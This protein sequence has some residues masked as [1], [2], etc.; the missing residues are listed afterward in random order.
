[1]RCFENGV[2]ARTTYSWDPDV[3]RDTLYL[4]YVYIK[5]TLL[6]IYYPLKYYL[7]ILY[8][9]GYTIVYTQHILTV[10]CYVTMEVAHDNP[11][12]EKSYVTHLIWSYKHVCKC[13]SN[14]VNMAC[15]ISFSE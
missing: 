12:L 7:Y 10:L 9:I 15:I 1:V 5:E 6:P 2:P 14:K 8:K 4:F 11:S 13:L 3:L